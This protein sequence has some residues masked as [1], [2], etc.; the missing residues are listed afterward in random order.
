MYVEGAIEGARHQRRRCAAAADAGS[1]GATRQRTKMN[2]ESSRSHSVFTLHI[3]SRTATGAVTNT[4]FAR[5]TLVDLAGSERQS[6]TQAAGD[7][8][9]EAGKIHRSLLALL[10]VIKALCDNAIV[11]Q[12]GR[13]QQRH[14][15]YRD[16]RLTF[17][18]KDS[19]GGN[20]KTWMIANVSP[21]ELS[22]GETLSTLKFAQRAKTIKNSVTVNEDVSGSAAVLQA[23]VRRLRAEL[24]QAQSTLLLS[25]S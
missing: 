8:L 3:E 14:V 5:M 25:S 11:A 24:A 17:L 9:R 12:T 2:D 6:D 22:F 7:T 21:S 16:S 18:L 20:T 23:E 1:A 15:P 10:N 19:L 13:G 4:R